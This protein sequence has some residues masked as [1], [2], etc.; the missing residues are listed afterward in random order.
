MAGGIII[1]Y[2]HVTKSCQSHSLKMILKIDS[3]ELYIMEWTD[4]DSNLVMM[5]TVEG[6]RLKSVM[7]I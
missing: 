2:R 1:F 7:K 3:K 6:H 4:K 5:F